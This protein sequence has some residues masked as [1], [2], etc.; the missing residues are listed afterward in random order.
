MIFSMDEDED[1]GGDDD[2]HWRMNDEEDEWWKMPR[3]ILPTKG[4]LVSS[5][6]CFSEQRGQMKQ[7]AD[8]NGY[9]YMPEM[10]WGLSK[11]RNQP[12]KSARTWEPAQKK[13]PLSGQELT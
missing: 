13:C 6:S 8:F 2:E 12:R 11:C 10:G 1:D 5:R 9:G 4:P 3:S 7:Q